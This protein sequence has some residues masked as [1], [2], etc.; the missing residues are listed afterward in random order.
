M[1]LDVKD[2]FSSSLFAAYST[3]YQPCTNFLRDLK[4]AEEG[5]KEK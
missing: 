2:L 5:G 4:K 1:S 3:D